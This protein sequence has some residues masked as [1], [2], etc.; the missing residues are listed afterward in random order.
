MGRALVEDVTVPGVAGGLA[1]RLIVPQAMGPRP[2]VIVLPEIDGLSQGTVASALRLAES[3]YV[4]LA[5]DL[6]TPFGGAPPLRNRHD[7]E[8]WVRR[9]DDRRQVSDLAAALAWLAGHSRVDAGRLAVMGFWA[10]GRYAAALATEPHGVSAVV[11]FY[12][13][14][15]PGGPLAGV[16]LAPGD[17]VGGLRAPLC[18][19]FGADDDLVPLPMVHRFEELLRNQ[20]GL[21][22]EVHVV[23]GGHYFANES[24]PRRFR[25]DSTDLAWDLTLNFLER[26]LVD[27]RQPAGPSPG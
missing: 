16:A 17:H 5:L 22:H 9:L 7:T 3:G 26:R 24:R 19:V 4:T 14:P 2:A 23:E 13:R 12:F 8:A 11:G 15:W 1:G 18:A 25:A 27:D 10:G 6:Y 21:G 20:P